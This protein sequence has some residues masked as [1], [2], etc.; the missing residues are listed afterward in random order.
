MPTSIR[1]ASAPLCSSADETFTSALMWHD[2]RSAARLR[3]TDP[4]WDTSAMDPFLDGRAAWRDPGTDPQQ[5][6][7]IEQIVWVAYTP[8]RMLQ[9]HLIPRGHSSYPPR[10]A[11]GRIRSWLVQHL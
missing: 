4:G 11:S 8:L 6:R 1:P 9:W 10:T 7:R 2:S 3:S 5:L